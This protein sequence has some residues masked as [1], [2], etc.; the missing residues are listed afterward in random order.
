MTIDSVLDA[1]PTDMMTLFQYQQEPSRDWIVSGENPMAWHQ[2]EERLLSGEVKV[3]IADD[4]GIGI[5]NLKVQSKAFRIK[6][7]WT[8]TNDNQM[9]W[10]RVKSVKT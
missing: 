7:L 8:F 3:A 10:K 4:G 6:W 5:N 2:G 1:L 9:L